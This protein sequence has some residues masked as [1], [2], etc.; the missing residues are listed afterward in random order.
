AGVAEGYWGDNEKT[1]ASFIRHETLGRL[2]RTGDFGVFRK[3][4]Y[5]E[6][7]GRRDSQVK[8]RGYRIELGEIE[9]RILEIDFIKEA[10]VIVKDHEGSN[11][12]L[13]AFLV[14]QPGYPDTPWSQVAEKLRKLLTDRLPDYMVPSSFIR[15]E[16]I[17]VNTTGKIDRKALSGYEIELQDAEQYVAPGTPVEKKLVEIFAKIVGVARVGVT[18]NFFQLGGDSLK[19]IAAVTEIRK[20]MNIDLPLEDIFVYLT[21][22]DLAEYISSEFDP[23]TGETAEEI[24]KVTYLTAEADWEN[25]HEPFELTSIQRAYVLGRYNYFEMGGTSTHVYQEIEA[26]VDIERLNLSLNKLIKRHPMLRAVVLDESRQKILDEIPEYR[27]EIEDFIDVDPDILQQAILKE[28]NRMSHHIFKIDTWPLFEIKSFRISADTYYL[29]IGFDLL[30]GDA[31]SIFIINKELAAFYLNPELEIPAL[32]FTFR[33]YIVA[34]EGIKALDVYEADQKYWLDLLEEFPTA[35]A[36]PLKCSPSTI[37]TPHFKRIMKSFSP[38]DWQALQDII[39]KRRLTNAVVLCTAYAEVMS[40]WSNQR[41]LALNLPVF[42]RYPFHKDVNKLIGDFTS[43]ILLR[44]N[45]EPGDNF[46]EKTEKVRLTLM[47]ALEHRL[48]SGVEFIGDLAKRDNAGT[49]AQM[50]IVFTSLFFDIQDDGSPERPQNIGELKLSISQTSQVFIDCQVASD[51]GRLNLNWDYVEELFDEK[52]IEIMFGQYIELLEAIIRGEEDYIF[53]PGEK[54]TALIK[55]YNSTVEDIP[56]TTLHRL[57]TN[58]AALS[59]DRIAIEFLDEKITYREMDERSN[60]VARYLREQGVKANDL[61]GLIGERSIFTIVNVMGILKAGGAYVPVDPEYPEDRKT[62]IIK[63]SNCM[64]TIGPDLYQLKKLVAYPGGELNNINTPE[65][66]AYIIHTSGSTGRP[67]GVIETHCAS[68][69][70]IFDINQRFAVDENDRIMGISS[71]C[72]DL[73]VYDIFGTLGAGAVLVL[74]MTPK[75]IPHLIETLEIKK[76]TLWNSVP[77]IMDL[78]IEELPQDYINYQLRIVMLS[79]DWIPLNLPGKI[80]EHFPRAKTFS[81]GGATEASIWSIYYP[82]EEVKSSWKSIPYGMPLANQEFYVLDYNMRLCPAEVVG[83]LYIGGIGLA[84]GYLN[85]TRKTIDSFIYHPQWGNLYRTGDYGVFHKE[86]HIEFLGRRD[87][88]VKLKGHRI[89]LGEIEN[90]LI[91]HEGVKSAIVIIRKG[92]ENLLC[93][94]IVPINEGAVTISQLKE[95]LIEKLP[96]YMIPSYFVLLESIPLTANGKVNKNALPEPTLETGIDY[97]AP[98]DKL[99]EELLEIWSEVLALKKEK[100]GINDSFFDRGGH[101]IIAIVLISKIYKKFNIKLP[102]G[103]LFRTPTIKGISGYLGEAAKGKYSDVVA[104]EKKEY[105]PMSSQQK[106]LYFIQKLEPENISYNMSMVLVFKEEVSREKLLDILMILMKR[107]EG[108]RTSFEIINDQPIQEVHDAVP[109]ELEYHEMDEEAA[110]KMVINFVKPFDLSKAPLLRAKLIKISIEKYIFLL[111]FHHIIIDAISNSILLND[112]TK[113]YSN[114]SVELTPLNIQYSSYSEWHLR[115]SRSGELD[116]QEA[117]WLR[118]FNGELPLLKMTTDFARSKEKNL[119]GDR[120]NLK[121]DADLIDK[122]KIYIRKSGTT[123]YIFMLSVYTVLLSKYSGQDDIIVGSPISGRTHPDLY[124]IIGLFANMLPMRNFPKEDIHFLDFIKDVKT[125]A[126]NAFENQEYQFTEL[127]GKLNIAKDLS[128]HPLFDAVIALNNE[129]VGAGNNLNKPFTFE[130]YGYEFSEL[131]FDLLLD[132]FEGESSINF[133][134]NYSVSLFKLS[135]AEKMLQH[136]VEILRQVIEDDGIMLKNIKISHDLISAES[137][138][139][140]EEADTFEF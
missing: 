92:G 80:K 12:I 25:I 61:V 87:Q 75:D 39:E 49:Q 90:Q 19:A 126:L 108:L 82:I 103:E 5:I 23:V 13:C 69:N 57:F 113:L 8:I 79:G 34:Y 106:G 102:L 131:K 101:S 15:L 123:T 70:T 47:E 36:L 41:Q 112:F 109:F 93:A 53:Q 37:V 98:R 60:R 2:Y 4:G 45:F 107:H 132:V 40:Y 20:Q 89:E 48:Y 21:I 72:F 73:S 24:K 114:R 7:L 28:R 134:L 66:L 127:V 14:M 1:A 119:K 30:V 29:F 16:Q 124:N 52:V 135:T 74:I 50:P 26:R 32:Q 51:G 6:F 11:K 99:E 56:P 104:V 33:D 38:Q 125:N 55:A 86:G 122:M 71:L 110:R 3:Q 136:F 54:E 111:D 59:P 9:T 120:V 35:P 43:V 115:L 17:P 128:R 65:D 63:S 133:S 91:K 42:N 44:I 77:T 10:V 62:Y 84:S 96:F 121:L 95:Y 27:I 130:S 129:N 138:I 31:A 116:R 140:T 46:W 85:D 76:I 22:R 68:G 139:P 83:E 64:L 118:R 18:E 88:Q 137:M 97:E 78:G 58:R 100:I 94:Y 67:K 117:Y 105:Y 81:L